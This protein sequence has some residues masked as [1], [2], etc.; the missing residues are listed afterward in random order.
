MDSTRDGHA[1]QEAALRALRASVGRLHQLS[2]GL[3]DEQ[4]ELRSYC[5]QWSVAD[6]LS[7]IG[8]GAV[9]WLRQLEDLSLIHI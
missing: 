3:R 1:D 2:R 8:S 7:H 4:L 5:T 9:I 6:V